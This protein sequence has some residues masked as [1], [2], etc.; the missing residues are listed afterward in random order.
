MEGLKHTSIG[1][2]PITKINEILLPNV[3]GTMLTTGNLRELPSIFLNITGGQ[4]EIGGHTG[5]AGDIQFGGPSKAGNLRFYSFINGE[6][7]MTFRTAAGCSSVEVKGS[8]LY[9][10]VMGIYFLYPETY[11]HKPV[12]KHRTESFFIFYKAQEGVDSRG[13]DR[14]EGGWH[15]GNERY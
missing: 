7:G 2:F 4:T 11:Q 5:F 12:W 8:T 1:S 10:H 13:E 9:P 3:S 14:G 6:Q 15:I